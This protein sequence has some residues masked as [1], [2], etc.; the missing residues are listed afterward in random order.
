MSSNY[1]IIKNMTLEEMAEHHALF[2]YNYSKLIDLGANLS[3]LQE[4]MK[5]WLLAEVSG[6]DNQ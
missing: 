2:L 3:G 4:Y 6:Y 5:D 1:D